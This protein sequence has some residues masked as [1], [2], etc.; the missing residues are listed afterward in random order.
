MREAN[1]R[2]HIAVAA[3]S[4]RADTNSRRGPTRHPMSRPSC[5]CSSVVAKLFIFSLLFLFYYFEAEF[6]NSA[7]SRRG[8]DPQVRFV[9]LFSDLEEVSRT[10]WKKTSPNK[11]EQK[12]K[13]KKKNIGCQFRCATVF[14]FNLICGG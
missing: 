6:K 7:G 10:F 1:Y 11:K 5:C 12:W 8:H 3:A 13:G 2:H 9:T 4:S 14:E